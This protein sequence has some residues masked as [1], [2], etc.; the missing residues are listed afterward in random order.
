VAPAQTR[1]AALLE[2]SRRAAES[3]HLKIAETLCGARKVVRR[4][5]RTHHFVVRR[6]GVERRDE[7]VEALLADDAVYVLVVHLRSC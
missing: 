7:T 6:L 4:V 3:H 2:I 1:V 5:H